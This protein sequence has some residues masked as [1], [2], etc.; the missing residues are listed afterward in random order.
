MKINVTEIQ[1]Q[2]GSSQDFDGEL[3]L[4]DFVWQNESTSFKGPLFIEGRITNIDEVLSLKAS[5]KGTLILMCRLCMEGYEHDFNFDFEAKLKKDSDQDDPE[6]FTYKGHVI[7][8]SDIIMEYIILELPSTRQCSEECMG[9]CSQCG[10]NRNTR[11]CDCSNDR[12]EDSEPEIDD[13]LKA[14]KDYFST[15]NKEV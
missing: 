12:D 15:Q 2:I 4:E 8:L 7:S 14:L 9:L 3:F 13:R 1:K 10:M 6:Y 11:T 5:L